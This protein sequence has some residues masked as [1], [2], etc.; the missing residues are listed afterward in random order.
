MANRE[1]Q[2]RRRVSVGVTGALLAALLQSVPAMAGPLSPTEQARVKFLGRANVAPGGGLLADRAVFSWV[3]ASTFVA[4]IGGHLVLLDAA[5]QRGV[6]SGGYIPATVQDLIDTRPEAILLGHGHYDHA[7]DLVQ[8][9]RSTDAKLVANSQVCR[10]AWRQLGGAPSF[11]CERVTADAPAYGDRRD[12]ALFDNVEVTAIVHPHSMPAPIMVPNPYGFRL[13]VLIP[14]AFDTIWNHPPSLSDLIHLAKHAADLSGGSVFYQVRV[15]PAVTHGA[16]PFAFAWHDTTGPLWARAKDVIGMLEGLPQTDVE[17]GTAIGFGQLTQ[18]LQDQ[19][20]YVQALQ[21]RVY[22]PMN[23]DFWFPPLSGH[24]AFIEPYLMEEFKMIPASKRKPEV[25][26]I[27][28]P[29]DYVRP[30]RLT[31]MTR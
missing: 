22:V 4:S 28:D 3:G 10:R 1:R 26:F 8:I 29:E 31:F 25:V 17:F 19:R 13:P 23:H 2:V 9:L 6:F 5:I 14:P 11:P 15:T 12:F 20:I 24:G 21:P 27:R 18:G 7:A 16:R 30:E